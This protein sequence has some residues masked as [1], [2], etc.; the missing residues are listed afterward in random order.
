MHSF[1]WMEKMEKWEISERDRWLSR[2]NALSHR[3]HRFGLPI[4]GKSIDFKISYPI[5]TEHQMS[6]SEASPIL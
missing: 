1:V 6:N 4:T 3:T 5:W 2:A